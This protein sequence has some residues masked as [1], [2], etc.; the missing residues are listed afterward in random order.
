MD[1]KNGIRFSGTNTIPNQ[2]VKIFIIQIGLVVSF[3]FLFLNQRNEI[4]EQK[5]EMCVRT[6]TQRLLTSVTLLTCY[7]W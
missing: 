4:Q 6:Q 3:L 5:T 2:F 1:N 7:F